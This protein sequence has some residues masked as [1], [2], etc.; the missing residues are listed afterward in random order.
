MR[1]AGM[2]ADPEEAGPAEAGSVR[3]RALDD[4]AVSGNSVVSSLAAGPGW[5]GVRSWEGVEKAV[6]EAGAGAAAFVLARRQ[7]RQPGHAFAERLGHA[8]AAYNLGEGEGRGVVWVDVSEGAGRRISGFPPEVAPSDAHAVVIDLDGRVTHALPALM[9]SASPAHAQLDAATGRRYGATGL[10]VEEDRPL[11]IQGLTGSPMKLDL[12]HGPG[13]KIVTDA[14]PYWVTADGR[15]H[16]SKPRVAPGEQAPKPNGYCIAEIVMDDPMAS[17]PGE[18]RWPR[19]EALRQLNRIRAALAIPDERGVPVPLSELLET[20]G[21]WRP[22]EW[23]ERTL[24]GLAVVDSSDSSYF[25]LTSGTVTLG[26]GALQDLAVDRATDHVLEAVTVSMRFFGQKT[27][28]AFVNRLLGHDGAENVLVPFLAA[29]PDVDEVFG[30]GWWGS[31]HAAAWP[32]RSQLADRPGGENLLTKN[33]LLVASRHPMDRVRRTLRPRTRTFLNE[34]YDE[35]TGMLVH[36]LSELLEFHRARATPDKPFD[37]G[38]FDTANGYVTA[39]EYWT[40]ILTG[41]TSQGTAVAQRGAI[42]TDD[43]ELDTDEGRLDVALVLPELRRFGYNGDI[44]MTPS[45]ISRAV[46]EVSGL[47]LSAYERA[48]SLP[49]P[50]PDDVLHESI[51]R[52]LDNPV[53]RNT[54][55]FLKVAAI[56]GVPQ[57][58]ERM[59]RKLMSLVESRNIALALGEYALG[60]LSAVHPVHQRLREAVDEAF[61]L[62]P[63][64]PPEGQQAHRDIFEAAWSASPSSPTLAQTP[65]EPATGPRRSSRCPVARRPAVGGIVLS[66]LVSP[67]RC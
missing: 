2:E 30:Y 33:L 54:A 24:V 49:A 67:F 29:I 43:Y 61:A 34:R 57:V 3:S 28:T 60:R 56:G 66:V 23:G 21:D 25:H 11:L 8:F 42:G 31:Q 37:A 63:R 4:S 36:H 26:L 50:L 15:L 14:R 59:P 58:G 46:E 18:R 45:E 53:V 22:T 44:Y 51:R 48:R 55:A 47:S 27:A 32:I 12:A 10:E 39:R 9:Q 65:P 40:A 5:R 16:R 41:R 17:L 20:L 38:F 1:P 62:L 64:I 13:F 35:L 52:I 19:Q 6:A 7:G